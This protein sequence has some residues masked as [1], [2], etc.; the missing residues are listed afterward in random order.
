MWVAKQMGYTDWTITA[1]IYARWMLQA[2]PDA[3]GKAVEKFASKMLPFSCHFSAK[4][5]LN[6]PNL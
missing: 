6:H 2:D 1:R 3:A 5:A 4:T